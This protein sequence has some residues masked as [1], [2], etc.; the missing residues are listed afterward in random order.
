MFNIVKKEINW[1]GKKLTLETGR[2]AR[3]ADGAVML[4]C[5]DTVILATAVAAKSAK[6]DIDFFPLTVNYQ[7]KYYASGKIPGGYFKR[8]ARPT[9]SETLISRLIDRPIRPLFPNSFRNEVQVLPTVISYDKDNDPEVLAL[10]A[11]SAA[12]AISGIPFMGPVAAAKVGMIDGNF[13][14]NPT[15]EQIVS[16]SLELVVAGTA[17]AVLMVESEASGLSE[18]QMLDAVKFGHDKAN[19]VINLIKEFAKEA[20]KPRWVIEEKDYTELKIKFQKQY[21]QIYK[22]LLIKKINKQ[23]LILLLKLKKNKKLF[24]GDETYSA[25]EINDQFKNVEKEIVRTQILKDSKRIDGRKLNEVRDI[26]CEVGVL[27]KVHGSALFTRGETQALVVATLG[28]QDDE[29]RLETLDGLVRSRFMLHYNFPPFSV[30]EVGRIGTGRREI[31]HGKLAWR[32]INASLPSKEEFPYTFRIVS[33]ITESNGSSS[34]ATVCGSSLALMDAGVP[35]KKPIAGIAMGLIKEGNDYSILSDILGDEDHLGDMDFKVAGTDDGIT[36]LQMDIKITGITFEIMEKALAQAKEGR[37]HILGEMAKTMKESRKEL[38]KNTPKMEKMQV[39][40][41]DIAA[42]IG[43]GG[44]TIR[45]IVELSG[46]KL[47]I[48]DDGVITIAAADEESRNKAVKMIKDIVAKPEMGK[49]YKGKVVKIMEFG[50]F[51][52]FLGK[53]D[54]LVHISQLATKRVE[55]VSDVV[56]EGDE[57]SVKVVGFDRGKVKLSM[58][59]AAEDNK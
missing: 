27:P 22:K 49:I 33:E 55:N 46:A 12:L 42:I 44:A 1:G 7:E 3:Q 37:I 31:G 54:G 52:N 32:A 34:M 45:E 53:Q 8:E 41:K 43:K 38:S 59:E 56:K 26:R 48:N 11:S 15:K 47:D 13:I 23:D 20:A 16:S 57:V 29:Q 21:L 58:K 39:D 10:I 40:K 14:L 51:V 17:D 4:T 36:S 35:I 19:E 2:V 30:G 24:D 50:A 6:P 18:K 28:T 9:E 25:V 5:G